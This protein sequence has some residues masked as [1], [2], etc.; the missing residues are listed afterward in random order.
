M[1]LEREDSPQE[2]VWQ[3]VVHDW[4]E[5]GGPEGSEEAS[6]QVAISFGLGFGSHAAILFVL[7]SGPHSILFSHKLPIHFLFRFQLYTFPV[8]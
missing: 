7:G 8:I 2:E 6:C 1:L 4:H 5:K 3:R